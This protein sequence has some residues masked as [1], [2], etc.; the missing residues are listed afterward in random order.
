MH[1]APHVALGDADHQAGVGLDQMLAR[2]QAVEDEAF[3]LGAFWGG[4]G[5]GFAGLAHRAQPQGGFPALLDPARQRDFLLDGQ[6][7]NPRHFL[8]I[9]PDRIF[10]GNPRQVAFLA[11]GGA[12]RSG[13][14]RAAETG[15]A[16][17]DAGAVEECQHAVVFTRAFGGAGKRLEDVV[18]GDVP[19]EL[20]LFQQIC[21]L[22][23]V[24]PFTLHAVLSMKGR[25]CMGAGRLS[26]LRL[27]GMMGTMPSRPSTSSV[28]RASPEEETSP[29]EDARVP[30]PTPGFWHGLR[31]CL[32]LCGIFFLPAGGLLLCG[33]GF[34]PSLGLF[35]RRLGRGF[36]LRRFLFPPAAFCRIPRVGGGAASFF[37]TAAIEGS[38]IF[39]FRLQQDPPGEYR[40]RFFSVMMPRFFVEIGAA[41]RAQSFA[42]RAAQRPGGLVDAGCIRAEA[43]PDLDARLPPRPGAG[44]WRSAADKRRGLRDGWRPGRRTASDSGRIRREA[45][46]KNRPWRRYP[47]GS[48]VSWM[49]PEKVFDLEIPA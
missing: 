45:G 17:L 24:S 35:A 48:G 42:F 46:R 9:Q 23:S 5:G 8:E 3:Q 2:G 38:S 41:H 39:R 49:R 26:F 27:A 14:G 31:F 33:G 29:G 47:A 20:R 13:P 18:G 7:R 32:F 22:F 4:Q 1:A 16:N 28:S 12:P 43:V 19:L 36:F 40:S 30:K 15:F 6:Q 25:S 21:N 44:R 34:L 37:T 11:G 10:D